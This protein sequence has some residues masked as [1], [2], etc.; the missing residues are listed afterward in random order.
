MRFRKS[1]KVGPFRL[2]FSNAG[3]GVSVGVKGARVGVNA[4]G[5]YIHVGRGGVYYRKT[6]P[7]GKKPKSARHDNP[8]GSSLPAVG[9]REEALQAQLETSVPDDLKRQLSRAKSPAWEAYLL[10]AVLYFR[11]S[12]S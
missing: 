8:A 1:K 4:R 2:N 5:S 12:T 3:V 11:P 9:N 7:H 6:F 10:S